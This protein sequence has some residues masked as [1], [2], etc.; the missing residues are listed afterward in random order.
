MLL[1]TAEL[2]RHVTD[3][4]SDIDGWMRLAQFQDEA[5]PAAAEVG[6]RDAVVLDRMIAIFERALKH[7]PHSEALIVEH[8]E[9]CRRKLDLAE[10]EA[11]WKKTVFTHASSLR[12]WQACLAFFTS[13]LSRFNVLKAQSQY[14]K[15]IETLGAIEAGSFAS[16]RLDSIVAQSALVG[17]ATESIYFVRQ[18][19]FGERALATF[20]AVVE[21]AVF[22]PPELLQVHGARQVLLTTVAI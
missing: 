4:P 9:L 20:Q 15:A 18:C 8:L 21:F 10:V 16:H 3:N 19:G 17:I 1:R 7:N 22:A 5:V 6:R 2:N 11:R 12:L 13:E 14:H